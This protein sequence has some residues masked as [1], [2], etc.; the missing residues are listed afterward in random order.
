MDYKQLARRIPD[1]VRSQRIICEEDPI[2]HAVPV[3]GNYHMSLLFEVWF[4]FIEPNAPKQYNCPFCLQ[5]VLNNFRQMKGALI[6]LE[7]EYQ[8]LNS[9]P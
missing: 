4:T 3:Q 7:K 9:L 2:T 8:L 5:N 1:N 6:E